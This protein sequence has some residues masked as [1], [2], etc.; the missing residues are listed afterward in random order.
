M[1]N[2]LLPCYSLL[3]RLLPFVP[4]GDCIERVQRFQ[5]AGQPWN[6]FSPVED[7][8]VFN[9]QQ[10]KSDHKFRQKNTN[11]ILLE[12][13]AG[14]KVVS[15]ACRSN[16]NGSRKNL[17]HMTANKLKVFSEQH[18]AASCAG[19]LLA[20]SSVISCRGIKLGNQKTLELEEKS[21]AR[22]GRAC[23]W[24]L[25]TFTANGCQT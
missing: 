15:L 5:K 13:K 10:E 18:K 9:L 20:V 21:Q 25:V 23:S 11:K 8:W 19:L 16:S 4:G 17:Q 7:C 22:A 1:H 2:V 24:T 3:F 14:K 6:H 12:D